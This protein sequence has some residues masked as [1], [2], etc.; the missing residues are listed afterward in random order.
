MNK[1]TLLVSLF[2]LVVL[3]MQA[4]ATSYMTVDL[5]GFTPYG[6]NDLGQI[7]G[8][9]R[10]DAAQFKAGIREVDGSITRPPLWDEGEYPY[11]SA[12]AISNTG[13]VA[14]MCG[15]E[16]FRW[17]GVTTPQRLDGP[18]I[19]DAPTAVNKWGVVVGYS[20]DSDLNQQAV[21]WKQSGEM[22]LVPGLSRNS[23]AWDINDAGQ[24][25]GS[26][27]HGSFLWSESAGLNY[28]SFGG[29]AINNDGWIA[30]TMSYADPI[31]H[32]EHSKA[33]LWKPAGPIQD[34][35]VPAGFTD[36]AAGGINDNGQ[37]VGEAWGPNYIPHVILWNSDGSVLDLGEGS[38]VALN[39]NGQVIG[40]WNNMA[41]GSVHNILWQPVPEPSSF[42]AILAGLGG[43][44]GLALRR[45]KA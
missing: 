7:A 35:G 45:R 23:R 12:H 21:I 8:Q 4:C 32:I 2:A 19:K 10:T 15:P 1:N 42:L 3:S 40:T 22:E 26:D 11:S 16:A 25:L 43:V 29:G 34:L 24:V 14:G 18:G 31:A 28:L 17:D 37:V 27:A 39:N 33:V 6:L 41:D 36:F 38:P 5:G 9:I 13:Y 30:G 20:A 44:G